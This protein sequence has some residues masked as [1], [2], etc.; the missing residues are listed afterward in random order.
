V[1]VAPSPC[2]DTLTCYQLPPQSGEVADIDDDDEDAVAKEFSRQR[3][4]MERSVSMMTRL[5]QREHAVNERSLAQRM[6][7]NSVLMQELNNIRAQKK[8]LELRMSGM[9]VSRRTAHV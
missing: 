9:S 1:L 8:Q 6:K 5:Q 7:E 4:F 3:H 2:R